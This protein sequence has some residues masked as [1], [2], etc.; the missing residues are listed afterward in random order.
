MRQIRQF[1]PATEENRLMEE[2]QPGRVCRG[3]LFESTWYRNGSTLTGAERLWK[4][5]DALIW[6]C[7]DGHHAAS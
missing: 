4:R 5:V 7:H 3:V 6:Y 1:P 2:N